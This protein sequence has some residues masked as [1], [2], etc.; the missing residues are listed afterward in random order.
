MTPSAQSMPNEFFNLNAAVAAASVSPNSLP[1]TPPAQL[2]SNSA[3]PLVG[4]PQFPFGHPDLLPKTGF[5]PY[6]LALAQ[7]NALNRSNGG[8]QHHLNTTTPSLPSNDRGSSAHLS[9]ASSR[10]SSSSPPPSAAAF[11]LHHHA[12]TPKINHSI[13]LNSTNEQSSEDSDDEHIDV[14]KSAF[15]PILRPQQQQQHHQN[16]QINATAKVNMVMNSPPTSCSSSPSPPKVKCDLK[17]PSSK[18]SVHHEQSRPNSLS[19]KCTKIKQEP[20]TPKTVWRPY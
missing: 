16:Q 5:L 13:E 9:P 14:V 8:G 3:N 2:L 6:D 4:M 20:A 12:S 15:V 19:P 18:R 11:A 10:N 17:A 1:T 7:R